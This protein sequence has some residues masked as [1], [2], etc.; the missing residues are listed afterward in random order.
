MLV[1][2]ILGRMENGAYDKTLERL[3]GAAAVP[4]RRARWARVIKEFASLYG[5]KD[6]VLF[7][8]PGRTELSGNHTDHNNGTVLAAS[9]DL[10]IIAVAAK[11][12]GSVVK[13]KSEGYREDTV[14]LSAS[15]K[16]S[17]R[18]GSSGAIIAGVA[19]WFKK[20]GYEC[21]GFCA[22]TAS[23]V[24]SGSGLSSSAAF[25]VMCGRIFSQF[26]NGGRVSM[27]ELAMAGKYAEN[28]FFGKP[29]GLMDQAAC[30]NGGCLWLDFADPDSPKYEKIGLDLEK[31]GFVLC[32]VNTGGNH[33]DLTSDYAAVPAEM[34]A[35]AEKLGASSLRFCDEKAFYENIPR[36]RAECGDR[37]VLRALHFFN[38]NK[39][40]SE[41]REALGSGD[42]SRYLELVTESGDS[43]FKYLQNVYSPH[44][45]EEQGISL[46]LALSESAGAAACRVHGGG[47]AGTIQAYVP[48]EKA[49]A[50]KKTLESV[51]GEKCCYVCRVRGCGASVVT[52]NG[53]E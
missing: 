36:L 53:A 25:E 28:E 21:G 4:A 31:Q 20:H 39:R 50:Y 46:A 29:C 13:M 18:C 45:P 41:Q 33:A 30:A 22:C 7:S 5:E 1:S 9:V 49:A 2:A 16:N 12:N 6:A 48:A 44:A 42:F 17:V 35:V 27:M 52:E 15:D 38:E 32:I 11:Q 51:F 19:D 26:Y 47:F 14:D 8:V 10:D 24:I 34:R 3:Y 37:A 43:S 40:V 23:D